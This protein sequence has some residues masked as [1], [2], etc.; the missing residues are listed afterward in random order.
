MNNENIKQLQN[1]FFSQSNSM[2]TPTEKAHSEQSTS[3]DAHEPIHSERVS[4]AFSDN[5]IQ[6][7]LHEYLASILK[8]DIQR[9]QSFSECKTGYTNLDNDNVR[10]YPG[11]YAVGGI[12]SVGKTTFISQL[13]DQ[14]AQQGQFVIFFSL[15]Q[16]EFELATK[17]IARLVMKHTHSDDVTAV[18]IRNGF[19]NPDIENAINEYQK[20]AN[21]IFIVDG[22]LNLTINRIR[23]TVLNFS[24]IHQCKPVVF[25]DYLQIIQ[26]DTNSYSSKF[27]VDMSVHELKMLSVELD[28]PVFVISSF[29][30]SNYLSIADFESFK[31]SGGI[32]YTADVVI[33]LQLQAMNAHIFNSQGDL[34]I[35]RKFVQKAK[36]ENPRKIELLY[37]KNRFGRAFTRY[38]FDYYPRA[39]YFISSNIEPNQAD[40]RI[41]SE[42]EKFKAQYNSSEFNSGNESSIKTSKKPK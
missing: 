30:R 36:S 11:L 28:I 17:G 35:K 6:H 27:G 26:Q 20:F 38:F 9:F 19:M 21:K 1:I 39:D 4:E 33:A 2:E 8:N 7:S 40:E 15:E 13:A 12:S 34:Q 41:H 24:Q 37:L 25:L 29:N 23:E 10:L 42:A 22:K 31:E 14:V 18:H 32:E 3:H 16:S 5:L